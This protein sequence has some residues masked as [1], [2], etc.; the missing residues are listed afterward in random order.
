MVDKDLVQYVEEI[1]REA[2]NIRAKFLDETEPMSIR[3]P[4]YRVLWSQYAQLI[5]G[6]ILECVK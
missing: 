6:E 5:R 2:E 1:R 4:G 3:S